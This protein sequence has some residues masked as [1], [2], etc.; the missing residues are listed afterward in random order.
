MKKKC[1]KQST[2]VKGEVKP[3]IHTGLEIVKGCW[4]V[5]VYVGGQLTT[6]EG[7]LKHMEQGVLENLYDTLASDMLAVTTELVSRTV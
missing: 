2:L 4:I 7:T 5:N 1:S 3:I 6:I